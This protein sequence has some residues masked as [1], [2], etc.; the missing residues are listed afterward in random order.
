MLLILI[1]SFTLNVLLAAATENSQRYDYGA[2][3]DF[4]SPSNSR[5]AATNHK[6]NYNLTY[7]DKTENIVRV[8]ILK[9]SHDDHKNKRKKSPKRTIQKIIKK[10]NKSR[11]KLYLNQATSTP[12]KAPLNDDLDNFYAQEEMMQKNENLNTTQVN[13]NK[14][15]K[16]WNNRITRYPMP[17]QS[18]GPRRDYHKRNKRSDDREDVFILTDLDEIEFLKSDKDDNVV[19]A[20][21][22]KYW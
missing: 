21:F 11:R 12:T 2:D 19:K 5:M 20:H 7:I 18:L 17:F 3:K 15:K 8:P 9:N 10:N 4:R 1:Y 16:K 14:K 6:P 13:N 22:K